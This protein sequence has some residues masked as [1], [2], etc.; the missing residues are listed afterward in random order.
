MSNPPKTVT[1]SDKQLNESRKIAEQIVQGATLATLR[2]VPKKSL[3]ALYALAYNDYNA[4]QYQKAEKIFRFL[5]LYDHMEKRYWKGLAATLQNQGKYA[6]AVG[7]YAH[8]ALLD[9]DDPEPPFQASFCFLADKNYGEAKKALE[10]VVAIVN[11]NPQH[12]SYLAKAQEL[13]RS[14]D[15]RQEQS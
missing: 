12:K 7:V 14:L 10:A 5:C 9:M 1:A 3:D 11:E 8:E 4:G 2:G 6:Q 13:L 15:K